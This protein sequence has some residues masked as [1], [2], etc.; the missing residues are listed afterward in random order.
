MQ[1]MTQTE[2]ERE[3]YVLSEG[4]KEINIPSPKSG[5]RGKVVGV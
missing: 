4:F 2:A 3:Y 5:I 1:A